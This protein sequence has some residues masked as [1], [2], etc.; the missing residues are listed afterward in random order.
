MPREPENATGAENTLARSVL[1]CPASGT[2]IVSGVLPP[3]TT[4]VIVIDEPFDVQLTS[5]LSDVAPVGATNGMLC[6]QSDPV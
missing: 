5:P 4:P 6:M 2:V 3:M 1:S